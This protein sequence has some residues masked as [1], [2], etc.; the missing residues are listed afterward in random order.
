MSETN[1]HAIL[2]QQMRKLWVREAL[3]VLTPRQMRIIVLYYW[4]GYT[5]KEIGEMFGITASRVMQMRDRAI[6]K[7]QRIPSARSI[8]VSLYDEE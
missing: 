8:L 2:I 3:A 5:F 1:P 7:I 6:Q 4:A